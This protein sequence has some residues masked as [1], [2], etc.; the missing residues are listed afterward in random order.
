MKNIKRV[1]I[2]ANY[3]VEQELM[4]ILKENQLDQHYTLIPNV[5]GNGFSNPKRGNHVWP[6]K[7]FI[8][9]IY[10]NDNTASKL[11]SIVQDLHKKF[12]TEGICCFVTGNN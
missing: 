7:N 9:L 4:E 10:G 2:I 5:T 12:P 6:E 1:E 8:L 3:S 11:E